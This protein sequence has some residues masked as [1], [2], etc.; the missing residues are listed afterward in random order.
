MTGGGGGR[1]GDISATCIVEG[2]MEVDH[3]VVVGG[4]MVE[5]QG[6]PSFLGLPLPLLIISEIQTYGIDISHQLKIK[7]NYIYIYILH[8]ITR[9]KFIRII[10]KF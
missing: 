6:G 8:D 5:E 7:N 3:W 9:K 1:G 4:Y 10:I 2:V